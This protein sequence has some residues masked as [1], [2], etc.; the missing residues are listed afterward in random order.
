VV[1][2]I[3][4][5]PGRS[6][7]SDVVSW[8]EDCH[9]KIRFFT[10][11][12]EKIAA[13]PDA[14]PEQIADAAARVHRYFSLALPLHVADEEELIQPLLLGKSEKLDEALE[15]MAREHREHEAHQTAVTRICEALMKDPGRAGE[16]AKELDEHTAALTAA[17]EAHLGAE[18]KSVFPAIRA[19]LSAEDRSRVLRGMRERRERSAQKEER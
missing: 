11:M 8:L 2:G 19:L 6:V 18:E 17:W 15:A 9:R 5:G 10:A 13:M 7:E 1:I 14:P 3:G 12:A 16:L 4:R